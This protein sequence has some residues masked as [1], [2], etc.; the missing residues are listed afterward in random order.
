MARSDLGTDIILVFAILVLPWTE[1]N[2]WFES[3][4]FVLLLVCATRDAALS[5]LGRPPRVVRD[6]PRLIAGLRDASPVLPAI[7]GLR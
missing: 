5:A 6:L 3:F 2:F 4:F 1:L 7:L